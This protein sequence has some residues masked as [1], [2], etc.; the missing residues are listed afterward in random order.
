VY[1]A[2]LTGTLVLGSI[3]LNYLKNRPSLAYA[4]KIL[5]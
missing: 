3:S 5:G 4:Y 2:P 1:Q